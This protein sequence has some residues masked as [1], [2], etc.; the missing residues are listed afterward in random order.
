MVRSAAACCPRANIAAYSA[1]PALATIHGMIVENTW[2]GPLI[3]VG[4]LMFPRNR[5]ARATDLAYDRDKYE[6]SEKP[7]RHI[8]HASNVMNPV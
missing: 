6:A 8:S 4:R 2:I 1:L 7:W 5:Y 3:W